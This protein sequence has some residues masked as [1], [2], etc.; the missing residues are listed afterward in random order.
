L[1]VGILSDSFRPLLQNDALRG[2][3]TTV[4][5]VGGAAAVILGGLSARRLRRG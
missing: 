4:V 1:V 3:L 5:A 2:A